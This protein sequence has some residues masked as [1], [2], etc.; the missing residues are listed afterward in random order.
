[1]GPQW[2][3][4]S[5]APPARRVIL[6]ASLAFGSGGAA[7]LVAQKSLRDTNARLADARLAQMPHLPKNSQQPSKV[8]KRGQLCARHPRAADGQLCRGLLL[9]INTTSF[10][11]TLFSKIIE[12]SEQLL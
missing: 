12:N 1:M 5:I 11:T 8:T 3:P 4:C 7:A 6:E 2:R 9:T 10:L